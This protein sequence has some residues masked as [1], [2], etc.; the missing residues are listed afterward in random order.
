MRAD[1][2]ARLNLF[3]FSDCVG[4]ENNNSFLRRGRAERVKEL[5]LR[6]AGPDRAFLSSRLDTQAAAM[7]EFIADNGTV[8]G[9]AMN[10]GVLILKPEVINIIDTAPG[11]SRGAGPAPR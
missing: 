10:R 7:D 2:S 8:A 9:R 6:L 3:G 5:L 1:P 4:R 11:R